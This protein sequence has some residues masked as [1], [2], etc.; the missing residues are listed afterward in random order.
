MKRTLVICLMTGIFS[1]NA[2]AADDGFYAGIQGGYG[3]T[4]YN[5]D[6][7]SPSG[8]A[9]MSSLNSSLV[10]S[11]N[12][13]NV[14]DIQN[15]SL[16]TTSAQSSLSS[17]DNFAGR[18]FVGYQFNPYIAVEAGYT[19]YFE[20][21]QSTSNYS[22]KGQIGEGIW[23]GPIT[24]YN[25]KANLTLTNQISAENVADLN[26]KL[27]YPI[28]NSPFSVYAKIGAAYVDPDQTVTVKNVVVHAQGMQSSAIASSPSDIANNTNAEIDSEICPEISPGISYDINNHLSADVSWTFIKGVGDV[29]NVNFAGVG[30]AYHFA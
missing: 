11:N 2:Y 22:G 9:V 27:M 19:K 30:L 20:D 1:L 24:Y 16:S 13:G 15:A 18:L 14:Y 26:A 21:V 25:A 28:A 7:L 8:A 29:Q 23:L 17:N 6:D 10:S 12:I 5:K 3:D 4:G